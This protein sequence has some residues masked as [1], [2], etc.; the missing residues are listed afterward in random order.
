[1]VA[2]IWEELRYPLAPLTFRSP[3]SPES[4]RRGPEVSEKTRRVHLEA[5]FGGLKQSGLGREQGLEGL[6]EFTEVK[7]VYISDV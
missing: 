1:M 6:H 4:G 2:V 3:G 5:P 7:N